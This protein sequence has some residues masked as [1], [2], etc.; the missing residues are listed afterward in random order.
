MLPIVCENAERMAS[1]KAAVVYLAC[2][3]LGASSAQA[4]HQEHL[5]VRSGGETRDYI[6]ATPDAALSGQ[7]PLILVLHGHLG[8][9]VNA[10]GAGLAPS[11]LSAWLDIVDRESVLVAALQ[12]LRGSDHRTGWHDCRSD[13]TRASRPH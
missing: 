10:L 5:S 1:V 3:W 4:A 12:G 13:D 2:A 6:L 11:P 8:T 9:A 7:R